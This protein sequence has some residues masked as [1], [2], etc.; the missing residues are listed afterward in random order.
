MTM[1]VVPPPSRLMASSAPNE[2]SHAAISG[3]VAPP[4]HLAWRPSMVMS[5]RVLPSA[6][7]PAPVRGWSLVSLPVMVPSRRMTAKPETTV[8]ADSGVPWSSLWMEAV[9]LA[10]MARQ[11]WPSGGEMVWPLRRMRPWTFSGPPGVA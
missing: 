3:V 1:V 9:R 2:W 6:E 4:L 10:V 11:G 8:A 7:T 5:Q